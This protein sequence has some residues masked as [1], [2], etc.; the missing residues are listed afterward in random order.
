MK[1]YRIE[2]S[3]S[4]SVTIFSSPWFLFV[5][6]TLF[7]SRSYTPARSGQTT[8]GLSASTSPDGSS[9]G[10]GNADGVSRPSGNPYVILQRSVCVEDPHVV[11]ARMNA[12]DTTTGCSM[13]QRSQVQT[14]VF[15]RGPVNSRRVSSSGSRSSSSKV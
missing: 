14:D 9:T 13:S 15:Q 4:D 3:D 2:T 8:C 12:R 6:A 7:L 11:M 1:Y 5:T 10:F